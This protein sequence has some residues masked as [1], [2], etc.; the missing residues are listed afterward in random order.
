MNSKSIIT[1]TVDG[2][3]YMTALKYAEIKNVSVWW[4]NKL[5]R[6]GKVDADKM[7]NYWFIKDEI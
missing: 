3:R 4:V 5:C 2:T 6:L 1:L 7:G